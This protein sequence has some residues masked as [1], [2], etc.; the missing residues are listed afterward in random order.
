MHSSMECFLYIFISLY[1]EIRQHLDGLSVV[2]TLSI[3]TIQAK[4]AL[5]KRPQKIGHLF[6][7]KMVS[8][9][10][11]NREALAISLEGKYEFEQCN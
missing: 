10:L 5:Q 8:S 3:V 7:G 11:M 9:M 2:F 6:S 1:L 4:P